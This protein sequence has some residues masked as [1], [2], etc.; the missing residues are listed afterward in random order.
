MNL[1]LFSANGALLSLAWG[2]APGFTWTEEPSALKAHITSTMSRAFSAPS[3]FQ[4]II[5]GAMPQA[6]IEISAFSA[7]PA[8][9]GRGEPFSLTT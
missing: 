2:N 8:Q 6:E 3:Y 4:S 1:Y 5:A 9:K 7:K